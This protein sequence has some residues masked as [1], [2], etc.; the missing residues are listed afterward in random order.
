[1]NDS[2][3]LALRRL[4]VGVVIASSPAIALGVGEGRSIGGH[5]G[6][7]T[8]LVTRTSE[9]SANT[10]ISDTFTLVVPIG[11]TAKLSEKLAVDFE[12]QVV[13]PLKPKGG[14]SKLVVAPGVVYNLGVVAAGLRVASSIGDP[15]NVGLIPII[16]RG[17][18]PVGGATWFVEAAFP[19]FWHRAPDPRV[20]FDVVIHTGIAF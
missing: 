18:F 12:T 10:D 16:N 7:A 13:S 11:V 2:I 19:T 8:P 3:W 1:M 17:L 9:S 5:I 6:V 14:V 15:P 20:T 4:I